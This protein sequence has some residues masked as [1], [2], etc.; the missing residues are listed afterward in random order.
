MRAFDSRNSYHDND[1]N[2]LHG[3]ITFYKNNTTEKAI[4]VDEYNRSIANPQPTNNI[5]QTN[6]NVFLLDNQDYHI[7]F[8]KL[9]EAGEYVFQYD[10]VN[11]YDVFGISVDS[12]GIQVINSIADL[13]NTDPAIIATQNGNK[14]IILAGYNEPGDKPSV[15]YVWNP[16][17]IDSDNGGSVIK[18]TNISTGRWILINSFVDGMDIRHFGVFGLNEPTVDTDMYYQIGTASEYCLSIGVPLIFVSNSDYTLT[19]YCLN[20]SNIKNCIFNNNTRV[21]S[22]TGSMSNIYLANSNEQYLKLYYNAENLLEGKYRVYGE[23]LKTSYSLGSG[24]GMVSYFPTKEMIVDS[25]YYDEYSWN[26]VKVTYEVPNRAPV[27]FNNCEIVSDHQLNPNL[28]ITFNKCHIKESYFDSSRLDVRDFD[29][30]LSFTDCYSTIDDWNTPNFYLRYCSKGNVDTIDLHNRTADTAVT[31]ENDITILNAKLNGTV[32]TNGKVEI[33]N[34][35]LSDLKPSD[36]IIAYDSTLKI[37]TCS[38]PSMKTK[39]CTIDSVYNNDTIKIFSSDIVDS[40]VLYPIHVGYDSKILNSTLEDI[41]CHA[42]NAGLYKIDYVN[43]YVNGDLKFDNNELNAD[44]KHFN[45]VVA[46]GTKICKNVINGTSTRHFID[47]SNAYLAN[48]QGGYYVG[49]NTNTQDN[50]VGTWALTLD[51]VCHTTAQ[52]TSEPYFAFS[53]NQAMLVNVPVNSLVFTFGEAISHTNRTLAIEIGKYRYADYEVYN[54]NILDLNRTFHIGMLYESMGKVYYNQN[55][56]K[57]MQ[58]ISGANY[59]EGDII[60]IPIYITCY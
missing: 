9:L 58:S 46:S 39:N 18:N 24:D 11:L 12:K 29:N 22:R 59:Q 41:I 21:Y 42:S 48:T 23:K 56:M 37:E 4:I 57:Q 35:T 20:N 60:H 15:Q 38:I 5:G 19:Y 47:K 34:C 14:V 53:N 8:E 27:T 51:L 32:T 43:N 31:F 45:T 49:E 17:S 54:G 30:R 40:T 36:S 28:V 55:I 3:R 2:L 13:R 10:T 1:G 33:N 6:D 7:V 50:N 26:N 25:S 44:V 52:T 16:N